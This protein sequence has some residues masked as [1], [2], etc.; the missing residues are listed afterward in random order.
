MFSTSVLE[1]QRVLGTTASS[2]ELNVAA[3][4]ANEDLPY[5]RPSLPAPLPAA[6]ICGGD[7]AARERRCSSPVKG[8]V[9][10]KAPI[11]GL[12][13]FYKENQ[14]PGESERV[15]K[16]S[17][18][19]WT[20]LREVEQLRS[21]LATEV[22]QR[23]QLEAQLRELR[24]E[25]QR[26]G[27]QRSLA[28]ATASA[29]DGDEEQEA[30]R[31][32]AALQA[33]AEAAAEAADEAKLPGAIAPSALAAVEAPA[34]PGAEAPGAT[35]AAEAVP[36]SAGAEEE[37]TGAS[38]TRGAT[39]AEVQTE[40]AMIPEAPV[41]TA[42]ASEESAANVEPAK[43]QEEVGNLRAKL[44]ALTEKR[45]EEINRTESQIKR[46]ADDNH[47]L[48][49][50]RNDLRKQKDVVATTAV[51]SAEAD[52]DLATPGID[53]QL[54]EDRSNRQQC[55]LMRSKS[56][57][58]VRTRRAEE[59]ACDVHEVER[60]LTQNR[61]LVL[62]VQQ[63]KQD[64]E[65]LEAE[66]RSLRELAAACEDVHSKVAGQNAHI[67]GHVNHKQKIRY[68]VQLK[69]ETA[70]LRAELKKTQKRLLQ[71]QASKKSENLVDALLPL[72]GLQ[73]RGVSGFASEPR[74][75]RRAMQSTPRG[76]GASELRGPEA[77]RRCRQLERMLESIAIDFRHFISLVE[78]VLSAAGPRSTP[79]VVS[80][81]GPGRQESATEDV[82]HLLRQ[83]REVIATTRQQAPA[84]AR[85]ETASPT[86]GNQ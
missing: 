11:S 30:S 6:P 44:V 78:R 50:E 70:Q 63:L 27:Q 60:L 42:G 36:A 77:D 18:P 16:S 39:S 56:V 1:R 49:S 83:L 75:P 52:I 62:T 82:P 37:A 48:R 74:T 15:R 7:V 53:G 33:E 3:G 23:E 29:F 84:E 47:R 26:S 19:V 64:S 45:L 10:G 51:A 4:V 59:T 57:I 72:A 12:F 13:S 69:E 85:P 67:M 14:P 81:G 46:L 79:G 17:I 65:L 58:C 54:V 22:A 41:V 25:R 38:E 40:T 71:M 43:L 5:R 35:L 9:A 2:D 8:G 21:Q 32:Q 24:A 76:V 31:E 28:A 80:V 73:P 34:D 86:R 66:N 61:E 68:M 55:G 20:H